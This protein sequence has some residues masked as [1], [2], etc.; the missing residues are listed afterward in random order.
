[1]LREV[2]VNA[3]GTARSTETISISGF[4]RPRAAG[5]V[6]QLERLVGKEWRPVAASTNT[7]ELGNFTA[8]LGTQ[9]RGVLALRVAVPADAIWAATYSPTFNII[10]R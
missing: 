4:I 10:I 5:A 6:V 9:P 2:A 8:T 3:P 7:D 1:M